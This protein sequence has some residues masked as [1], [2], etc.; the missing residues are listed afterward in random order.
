MQQSLRMQ[1][2]G[3][4]SEEELDLKH[5]DSSI[6]TNLWRK[7]A[8][9]GELVEHDYNVQQGRAMH[10]KVTSKGIKLKEGVDHRETKEWKQM[11]PAQ[12]ANL[13]QEWRRHDSKSFKNKEK[14]RIIGRGS[15]SK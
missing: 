4:I 11:S 5:N 15:A 8:T 10:V 7:V 12:K 6:G 13:K 3:I 9:P 2:Q 14:I 1:R